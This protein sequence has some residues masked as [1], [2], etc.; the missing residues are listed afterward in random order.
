V[1]RPLIVG[2]A[3]GPHTDPDVPLEGRA[4]RRLAALAGLEEEELR[5]RARIVNVLPR[6]PGSAGKGSRFDH[7]EAAGPAEEVIRR[8]ARRG[9]RILVLGWRAARALDP[10]FYGLRRQPILELE[11]HHVG[12]VPVRVAIVPHPS[13]ISHWWNDPANVERASEFLRGVL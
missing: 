3:P 8:H 2:E 7:R 9:Q 13:G 10:V 6:W 11:P 12:P 1:T 5:R 4:A